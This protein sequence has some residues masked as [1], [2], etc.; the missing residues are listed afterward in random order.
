VH[1][2]LVEPRAFL[3]VLALSIVMAGPRASVA[4]DAAPESER[5]TIEALIA[6]V[7]GLGDATFV[8]NGKSYDASS[9][10]RFLREKWKSRASEVKTAEDFIERVASFSSMTSLPY[11]IRFADGREIQSRDYLRAELARIRDASN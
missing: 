10:A 2:L 1:H 6:S 8:R 4:E 9:A 3:A 11:R 7:A 5:R